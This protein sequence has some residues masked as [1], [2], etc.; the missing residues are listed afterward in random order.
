[1]DPK[2][3]LDNL[4]NENIHDIE[5]SKENI[6]ELEVEKLKK[7]VKSRIKKG[8]G[9]R[10]TAITGGV[11]I[12]LIGIISTPTIAAN[13][14]II[15]DL[16]KEIGLFS[17]YEEYTNYIGES[18]ESNGYKV[19]I[20]NIVAIQDK[21]QAV[22]KIESSKAFTRNPK[23]DNFIINVNMDNR[24]KGS[25]SSSGT[26]NYY[27]DDHTIIL[28]YEE[29]LEGDK[30]PKQGELTIDVQKRLEGSEGNELDISFNV[31]IDFS[32]AFKEKYDININKPI[33]EGLELKKMVSNA[34]GSELNFSGDDSSYLRD[35]WGPRYYMEVDGKIYYKVSGSNMDFPQLTADVLKNAKS[36]NCIVLDT[37]KEIRWQVVEDKDKVIIDEVE[38]DNIIYTKTITL[39]NGLKGEVYNVEWEGDKLRFYFRSEYEP[40][41]VIDGLGV[42]ISNNV[43]DKNFNGYNN[44]YKIIKTD[45]GFIYELSG[46]DKNKYIELSY[47]DYGL[48]L[49]N[50]KEPQVIKIK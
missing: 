7:N 28:N 20:E 21:L 42:S 36:I 24:Q 13:I 14:P 47:G 3:I 16:Y 23:D 46:V 35:P 43:D 19:T 4:D 12:V 11:A 9:I 50:F 22:V 48:P 39:Q 5:L 37:K 2:E 27:I 49:D 1:M 32:S 10:K 30:Y 33:N 41:A 38:K 17:G 18:K 6:S 45:D 29:S 31:K 34:M 40:L 15:N 25:S 44:N 8:N 26:S